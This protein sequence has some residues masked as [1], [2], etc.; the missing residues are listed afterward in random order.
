MDYTRNR[1]F[2]N[3]LNKILF[4]TFIIIWAF[5]T[6]MLL[7]LF[8]LLSHG[9][10]PPLY[11]IYPI[12]FIVGLNIILF[13]IRG[14]IISYIISILIILISANISF[15]YLK[16]PIDGFFWFIILSLI[17]TL[18]QLLFSYRNKNTVNEF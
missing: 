5:S 12:V 9:Y 4:Y 7:I 8:L 16:E 2:R 1:D 18:I 13:Q 11:F 14:S 17:S 15:N 6:V 3:P 10:L